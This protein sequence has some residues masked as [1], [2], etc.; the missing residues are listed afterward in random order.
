[1]SSPEEALGRRRGDAGPAAPVVRILAVDDDAAYLR[2]LR[3]VLARAGFAVELAPSGEEALER[4]RHPPTIDIL[5]IDLAMPGLDGIETVRK[6]HKD[7]PLQELYTILLIASSGTETKLRALESGLDDYLTKTASESEIVAKVRSAA[8]RVELERRLHAANEELQL[9]ALT[10]ELTGIAN[11]RALFRTGEQIL[12]AGRSLSVV[13]FDLERFKDIN[14]T[15]GHLAGDRI[16]ASVA[17]ALK[18]Y[19]RYG[20][21]IGRYG[22]DEFFLLLPDTPPEEARQIAERLMGFLR[23]LRWTLNDTLVSVDAQ[24]GVAGSRPGSSLAELLASCDQMLY[25]GK[26]HGSAHR[27]PDQSARL[28]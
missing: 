13:L 10:D 28:R 9:L 7:G 14:D 25:R 3:L 24:Y 17:A 4:L 27:R 1:M 21:I 8:R 26:R 5:V 6:I 12:A 18:T 15:Y 2:F 11:R 20:D 19:T 23:Q 22:G 16:L